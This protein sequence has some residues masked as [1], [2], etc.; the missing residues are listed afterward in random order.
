[1]EATFDSGAI[2]SDAGVLLLQQ[3]ARRLGLIAAADKA[4]HDP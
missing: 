3:A 4:V 2:T 1:V